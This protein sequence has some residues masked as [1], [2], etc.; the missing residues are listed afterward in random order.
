MMTELLDQIPLLKCCSSDAAKGDTSLS[1]CFCT[2]PS[3]AYTTQ[4][5]PSSGLTCTDPMSSRKWCSYTPF[6]TGS[7]QL[8]QSNNGS[9]ATNGKLNSSYSVNTTTGMAAFTQPGASMLE[10]GAKSTMPLG[11]L[12]CANYYTNQNSKAPTGAPTNSTT[13]LS[14]SKG[15]GFSNWN[16]SPDF[17]TYGKTISDMGFAKS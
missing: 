10:S 7:I 8:A 3:V 16:T 11:S 5:K 2:D 4:C 17:T 15:S 6:S 12:T 9:F 13:N 14:F 1:H